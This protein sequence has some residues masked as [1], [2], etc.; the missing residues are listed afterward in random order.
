MIILRVTMNALPNKRK[1]LLQTLEAMSA[2]ISKEKGCWSH[3][4]YQDMEDKDVIC[5][6]EEWEN[7]EDLENYV[8]SDRF[9]ALLG[10]LDLLSEGPVIKFSEVSSTAGMDLVKAVRER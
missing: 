3:H 4:V 8:K 5:L 6:L 1:E 2:S 7:Q 9:A 10:A